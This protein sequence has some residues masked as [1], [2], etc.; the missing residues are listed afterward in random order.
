MRAERSEEQ[1]AAAAAH[2]QCRQAEKEKVRKNLCLDM[3]CSICRFL[4]VLL[5]L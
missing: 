4:R 5:M 2:A 3:V 1:K